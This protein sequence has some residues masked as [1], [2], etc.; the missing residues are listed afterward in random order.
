MQRNGA[1]GPVGTGIHVPVEAASLHPPDYGLKPA[2]S[3]GASRIKVI[4]TLRFAAM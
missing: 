4:V 2:G 3:G 1:K